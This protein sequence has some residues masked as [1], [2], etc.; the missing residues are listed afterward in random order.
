[1]GPGEIAEFAMESEARRAIYPCSFIDE[2]D[3]KNWD[4]NVQR[5][6]RLALAGWYRAFSPELAEQALSQIRVRGCYTAGGVRVNYRVDGTVKSGHWDTSSGNAAL[7]IEVTMQAIGGLPRALRPSEVRG[8]VMGDD[9]LLW[10][11]FDRSVDP[12]A[13]AAAISAAE[14]RLGIH[15]VRGLFADVLCASFC[16]LG[17]HR[18]AEGRLVALPKLGRC[19]AKLFWTVTP[20]NG[21]DPRRMASTVA[22]AFYPAFHSY[23][24]MRSFLKHHMQVPPLEVDVSEA[25]PYVLREHQLPECSGINWAESLIVKYGLPPDVLSDMTDILTSTPVGVVHHP[26]VDIMIEQDASDPPDRRGV[27]C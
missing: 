22:H 4:A 10:L 27:L 9:L 18:T 8:L 5:E 13:Y 19:F 11:Y 23:G 6:H 15:P 1:M 7:N 25:L 16:S 26:A 12:G 21:R 24:P 2:R 17:F 3:G 14:H 20:L